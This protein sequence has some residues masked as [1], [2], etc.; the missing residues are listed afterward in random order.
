MSKLSLT[1]PKQAIVSVMSGAVVA[2]A[3]MKLLDVL[4]Q[5]PPVVPWTVPAV[6]AVLGV[7]GIVYALLVPK[8]LEDRTIGAQEAFLA[9][10]T[11]KAM[12]VT[13]AVLAGAHSVY[14]MKYLRLVE[15]ETPL[16]RVVTGAGTIAASVLFA[17]AGSLIEHKLRLPDPPDDPDEGH[18]ES[19]PA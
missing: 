5:Y 18:A 16:R 13:G 3:G 7:A 10:V 6:L 9:V 12:I 2:W 14:V 15:A 11:G 4:G 19:S 1:T 8:R 17:V